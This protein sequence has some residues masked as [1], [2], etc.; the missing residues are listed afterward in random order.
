MC[1][2]TRA[3]R[4]G[5]FRYAG[6]S[7]PAGAVGRMLNGN[8]LESEAEK[9]L[10]NLI[11]VPYPHLVKFVDLVELVLDPRSIFFGVT[12]PHIRRVG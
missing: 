6:Q 9:S 1:M 10:R 4:L 11:G 5:K 12:E 2:P 3:G 7:R 8:A